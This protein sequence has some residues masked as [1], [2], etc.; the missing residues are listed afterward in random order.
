MRGVVD[1]DMV[2]VHAASF[3]LDGVDDAVDHDLRSERKHIQ[4]GGDRVIRLRDG[5]A[6]GQ[7][8]ASGADSAAAVTGDGEISQGRAFLPSGFGDRFL[9][10]V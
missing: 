9:R 6:V 3:I 7:S 1:I 10:G 8:P 4:I 2:A 5:A